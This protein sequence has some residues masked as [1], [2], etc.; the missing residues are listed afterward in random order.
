MTALPSL[1]HFTFDRYERFYEPGEDTFLLIDA[2]ATDFKSGAAAS[3]PAVLCV[4]L[5]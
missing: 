2:L 4:E 1:S 3:D 5:G